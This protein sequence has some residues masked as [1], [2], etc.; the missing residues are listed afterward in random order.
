MSESAEALAARIE[1]R[2][3]ASVAACRIHARQVTALVEPGA[4]REVC[5]ALRDEDE[6]QFGQ[7]VD[8]CGVDYM[9]Y[10]RAVWDTSETVTSQGFSRGVERRDD[11]QETPDLSRYEVVYHLLS[12]TR[13]QRLRIKVEA[14]GRGDPVRAYP[15]HDA[16]GVSASFRALNVG[17]RSLAIDLKQPAGRDLVLRLVEQAGADQLLIFHH[18]PTHDDAFMDQI[19][20]AAEEMRPGTQVAREGMLIEL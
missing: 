2:F 3:G 9:D 15:P 20:K 7:L 19:A 13:N 18:D 16:E 11:R 10:G 6:F 4:L 8:V 1:Q 12:H 17:K 14:P 5:L